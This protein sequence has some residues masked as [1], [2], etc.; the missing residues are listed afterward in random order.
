LIRWRAA[1]VLSAV[2]SACVVTAACSSHGEHDATAALSSSAPQSAPQHAPAAC[3]PGE[4]GYLRA[5]LRGAI[6]TDLDW[7]GEGLECEGGARPDHG[8]L[9]VSFRGP[10]DA[11]GRRLRIVFGMAV[12]PGAAAHRVVPTNITVIVEGH[13]TLYATQGE[14]KCTIEALVQQPLAQPRPAGAPATAGPP[15]DPTQASGEPAHSSHS[16]RVAARGYCIDPASTLDGS[17]RLYINRFDFAG[18]GRF[19]DE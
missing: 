16:Y 19:D 11:Q 17:G 18:L 12:P 5:S 4:R 9:R 10:A 3:L 13:N 6:D 7:R 2:A 1:G 14:D 15:G 8:G